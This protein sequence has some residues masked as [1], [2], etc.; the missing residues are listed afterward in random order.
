MTRPPVC[1]ER[2]E[3]S[4]SGQVVYRFRRAWRSG[5][6]AV[7]LDPKIVGRRGHDQ[8]CLAS[9]SSSSPAESTRASRSRAGLAVVEHRATQIQ[10]Y[11][12]FEQNV[13][14]QTDETKATIDAKM[15]ALVPSTEK[16][17]VDATK[18]WS[19]LVSEYVDSMG[20]GDES[21]KLQDLADKFAEATTTCAK[22]CR[23]KNTAACKT[24]L[25]TNDELR[26]Q[27]APDFSA[28]RPDPGE[29]CEQGKRHFRAATRADP[30]FR[31]VEAARY[32]K[33]YIAFGGSLA[34]SP[35]KWLEDTGDIDILD[36]VGAPTGDTIDSL[37]KSDGVGVGGS[38]GASG[39]WLS[40]SGWTIEGRALYS[41]T[42]K[43]ADDEVKWCEN[44][45]LVGDTLSAPATQLCSTR[46]LGPPNRSNR[47][48]VDL[49]FGRADLRKGWWRASLGP[50]YVVNF[51]DT[52]SE[53]VHEIG[54]HVPVAFN[55][56]AAPRNNQKLDY[57]GVFRLTPFVDFSAGPGVE[58]TPVTIGLSLALLGKRSLF[59]MKY[60]EF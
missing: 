41:H 32:Q 18:E 60:D 43:D 51:S 46:P 44:K 45:G 5:A 3:V 53:T 19:S 13:V 39:A 27:T 26:K 36:D 54:L 47:V 17:C 6:H 16:A 23:D 40:L 1:Q 58:G 29:L 28:V 37:T 42:S 55:F 59:S 12:W 2:L 52:N 22:E 57:D 7:V 4:S 56:L 14:K 25:A 30:N 15:R 9:S 10:R 50:R 31:R 8:R 33:A 21:Q 48:A 34:V 24:S 35:H 49:R 11:H 20:R 38:A